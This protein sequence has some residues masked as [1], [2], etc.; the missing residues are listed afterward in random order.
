MFMLKI[1]F[2][3]LSLE[4]QGFAGKH[5]LHLALCNVSPRSLFILPSVLNVCV[6]LIN[7]SR[8]P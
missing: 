5:Q 4:V 1:D 3:A 7:K 8:F 2:C 6:C